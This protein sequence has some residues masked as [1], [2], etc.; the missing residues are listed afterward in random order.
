MFISCTSFKEHVEAQWFILAYNNFY[1]MQGVSEMLG[2][3]S[4]VS[5]SLQH[6]ETIPYKHMSGYGYCLSLIERLHAAIN[7]LTVIFYLQLI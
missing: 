6:K 5:S 1:H 4:R 2:Q 7:T 3:T